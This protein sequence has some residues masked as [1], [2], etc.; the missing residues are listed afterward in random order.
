[1]RGY[2]ARNVRGALVGLRFFRFPAGGTETGSG[3]VPLF[4]GISWFDSRFHVAKLNPVARNIPLLNLLLHR[5][6]GD[7]AECK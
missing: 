1:M 5:S 3:K 6:G 7:R 4:S 2:D